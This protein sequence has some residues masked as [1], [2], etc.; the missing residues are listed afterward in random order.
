MIQKFKSMPINL[1]LQIIRR[2]LEV[3]TVWKRTGKI[4]VP[5]DGMNAR[6]CSN[7]KAKL[8][9]MFFRTFDLSVLSSIILQNY[10]LNKYDSNSDYKKGFGG[11]FGIQEDR[12]DKSALGWDEHEK[13]QQHESQTGC[14]ICLLLFFFFSGRTNIFEVKRI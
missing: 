2:V 13:L 3:N 5:M 6:N 10:Y 11:K 8:V 14:S 9:E 12:K 7:M 4:K 1:V